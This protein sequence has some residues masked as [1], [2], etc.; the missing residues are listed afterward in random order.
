MTQI[1]LF[2]EQ[3]V[4]VAVVAVF[5]VVE[6]V[7]GILKKTFWFLK[8]FLF[9][10]ARHEQRPLG[11]VLV[12]V[13]VVVVVFVVVVF[14]LVV[15]LPPVAVFVSGFVSFQPF[16]CQFFIGRQMIHAAAAAAARDTS[17][18]WLWVVADANAVRTPA[19]FG[20][21]ALWRVVVV[22]V[23]VVVAVIVVVVVVVVVAQM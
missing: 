19:W 6:C 20:Q 4:V 3:I 9:K 1:P 14:S 23:V 12:V 18:A 7:Q 8:T 10:T 13:V 21:L 16:L 15:L 17:T 22:V 11:A 2:R 5:A